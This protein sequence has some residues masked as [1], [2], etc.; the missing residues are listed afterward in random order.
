MNKVDNYKYLLFKI[1]YGEL[2]LVK[3][4]VFMKN[5][6][7]PLEITSEN[8]YDALSNYFFLLNDINEEA[9][10]EQERN[11]FE[12]YFSKNIKDLTDD[13]L[14]K[15]KVF[16]KNTF[17]KVIFPNTSEK[18]IYYGPINDNF[19]CPAD[20]IVLGIYYDCTNENDFD[21]SNKLADIA[22]DIQYNSNINYK[23]SVLIKNQLVLDNESPRIK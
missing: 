3:Y 8:G 12:Y 23:V 7:E 11:F 10:S 16:I 18:Y 19:L 21:I 15:I 2:N 1:L 17:P 13:E 6:V 5:N 9:F 4:E 14:Q 20:S 22:N